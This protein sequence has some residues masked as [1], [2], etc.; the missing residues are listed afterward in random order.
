MLDNVT[1]NDL[2]EFVVG[3]RIWKRSEIVNDICVTQAIRIDPD[4]TRK[5]VLTTT[6]IE[7]LSAFGH[8][9]VLV[10]QQRCEFVQIERVNRLAQRARHVSE[11]HA[12]QH[13]RF[14]ALQH[15]S[16][17]HYKLTRDTFACL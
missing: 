14:V 12:V 4:R 8:R 3:E 16:R 17:Y 7:N 11:M 9:S 5:L 13:D 1:A 2:V 6:D 15:L 10:Q